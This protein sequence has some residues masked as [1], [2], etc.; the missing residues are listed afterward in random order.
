MYDRLYTYF[1]KNKIIFEKQFGFRAD[2]ST[3]HALLEVNDE[4]CECLDEE[5]FF[6]CNFC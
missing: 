3:D 2:Y 5:K 6:L 4:I 1:T